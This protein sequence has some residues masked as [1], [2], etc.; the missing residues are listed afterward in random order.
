[1]RKKIKAKPSIK[2][3]TYRANARVSEEVWQWIKDEA[4]KIGASES[5]IVRRS[6]IQAMEHAN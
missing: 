6:I 3:N 2:D 4:M 5:V 1:M